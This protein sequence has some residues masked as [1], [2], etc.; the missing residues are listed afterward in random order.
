[1]FDEERRNSRRLNEQVQSNCCSGVDQNKHRKCKETRDLQLQLAC[2][3]E[4]IEE[5]HSE[6]EEIRNMSEVLN[7]KYKMVSQEKLKL[8]EHNEVVAYSYQDSQERIKELCIVCTGVCVITS[9]FD[10]PILM[11]NYLR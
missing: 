11:I 3:R 2:A 1:M 9:F 6:L 8:F 5:L 4:E 10:R 7:A